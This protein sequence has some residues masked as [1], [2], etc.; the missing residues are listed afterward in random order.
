MCQKV[1]F[2]SCVAWPAFEYKL[3]TTDKLKVV[4]NY[5]ANII[6]VH[7]FTFFIKENTHRIPFVYKNHNLPKCTL[8]FA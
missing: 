2:S 4:E 1:I 6:P 3:C 7:L 5:K 8:I